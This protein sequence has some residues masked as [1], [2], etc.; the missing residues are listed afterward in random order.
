M[1]RLCSNCGRA[2]PAG[3]ENFPRGTGK[4]RDCTRTYER[5]RS[6]YRRAVRGTT[7]QRGYGSDHQAL[8]KLAIARQPWCTDCGSTD[9]LTAD[10]II[11]TSKGGR[12]V[13]SNY[14]TRCRGCNHGKGNPG[15]GKPWLER[16]G[17]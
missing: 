2:F 17:F 7:T 3:L 11:P 13:L 9:D 8:A 1:H 10:H 16:A 5:E 6:R 15:R 12:N 14:A 4:C